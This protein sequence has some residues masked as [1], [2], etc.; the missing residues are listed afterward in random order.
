MQRKI[1]F[2]IFTLCRMLVR[3]S[4]QDHMMEQSNSTLQS[5]VYIIVVEK[6]I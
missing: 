4:N 3:R 5:N 2:I 1:N 6:N